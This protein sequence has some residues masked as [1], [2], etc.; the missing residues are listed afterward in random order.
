[1]NLESDPGKKE[2]C[3]GHVKEADFTVQTSPSVPWESPG[4]W[5]RTLLTWHVSSRRFS[6]QGAPLLRRVLGNSITTEGLCPSCPV[7][8]PVEE[9]APL[10]SWHITLGG[11]E[12]RVVHTVKEEDTQTCEPQGIES[13][14]TLRGLCV[15]STVHTHK[16]GFAS[17]A[18]CYLLLCILSHHNLFKIMRMETHSGPQCRD[19]K[20]AQ[21][22]L[23]MVSWC[24]VMVLWWKHHQT[25]WP[26]CGCHTF[27]PVNV[28]YH[29][30]AEL[31]LL[32]WVET[33]AVQMVWLLARLGSWGVTFPYISTT[34]R[35]A[36]FSLHINLPSWCV[37]CR[38]DCH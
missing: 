14:G 38:K 34:K 21:T 17:R 36:L 5:H 7:T 23:V 1:M 2:N 30:Q 9:M 3:Y 4:R 20:T 18:L 32:I 24:H 26:A 15:R 25:T 22:W 10:H 19:K 13:L 28:S 33:R 6:K 27:T 11:Q 29:G 31:M 16:H 12:S 37:L 35:K 8:Q